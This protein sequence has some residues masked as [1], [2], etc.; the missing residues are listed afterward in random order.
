M[1]TIDVA[2]ARS[3]SREMLLG[4]QNRDLA[5]SANN[6]KTSFSSWDN[7]M[8]ATYCK[9]P[10]IAAII[11]GGLIVLSVVWCIVRCCCCDKKHK[12]LDEPYFPPAFAPHSGYKAPD[13]MMSGGGAPGTPFSPGP[14]DVRF[15]TGPNGMAIDPP[16]PVN[17]DALPPMPSWDSAAKRRI[18]IEDEPGAVEL[19]ELDP[20]L[21]AQAQSLE[22]TAQ[23]LALH[24]QERVP[25]ATRSCGAGGYMSPGPNGRPNDQ[26]SRNNS[27]NGY[28]GDQGLSPIGPPGQAY[29]GRGYSPQNQNQFI[30]QA[31]GGPDEQYGNHAIGNAYGDDRQSPYPGDNGGPQGGAF[32]VMPAPGFGQHQRNDSGQRPF[33]A[34]RA[35]VPAGPLGGGGYSGSDESYANAPR[36]GSPPILSNTSGYGP[37]GGSPPQGG[38]RGATPVDSS[39]GYRGGMGMPM[40]MPMPQRV[41]SPQGGYRGPPQRVDSPQGFR[42]PPQGFGG[43]PPQQRMGS[44]GPGRGGFGQGPERRGSPG[45]GPGGFG[46]GFPSPRTLEPRRLRD[47]DDD[48]DDDKRTTTMKKR[49]LESDV[50]A[51]AAGNAERQEAAALQNP[52][53]A[54]LSS[55]SDLEVTLSL[56]DAKQMPF[57]GTTIDN[58]TKLFASV[59]TTSEK[60]DRAA[61]LYIA[62]IELVDMNAPTEAPQHLL[63]NSADCIY[64]PMLATC[65][66]NTVLQY[67]RDNKAI[68]LELFL[69]NAKITPGHRYTFNL[70]YSEEPTAPLTDLASA[71]AQN[72]AGG[73]LILSA[74]GKPPTDPNA[75]SSTTSSSTSTS[76]R[77]SNGGIAKPTG[78]GTDSPDSSIA[79]STTVP[80]SAFPSGISSGLAPP[81]AP[82]NK[83][84]STG[85]KAGI[86]VGVAA[87][88]LIVIALLVA[89]WAR[90]TRRASTR[91]GRGAGEKESVLAAAA[92][93]GSGE[94]RDADEAGGA[95]VGGVVG[96]S[97]VTRKPV[98]VP[99]VANE[100][101]LADAVSPA[102]TTVG[103]V[104]AQHRGAGGEG[105]TQESMLNAEE[106]E[107]W[108]EEER[109]LDE[110]I[111]EAE[112]RR[113]GA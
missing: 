110:D 12:H 33:T 54:Q 41:D 69:T 9:W 60:I 34:D 81:S 17:D 25:T 87:A 50:R 52:T 105:A 67:S 113:L 107:R 100:A 86:G 112:R 48:D 83:G 51:M 53:N 56:N 4:L 7:C 40:P 84:L 28:G 102:S 45:P 6:V 16:K 98:G 97:P 72:G 37:R 31:Q 10:I 39:G 109:R 13:P 23:E 26:F 43:P 92:P 20:A 103:V 19:G 21:Q 79:T 22:P 46:Q 99:A 93:G 57:T 62:G 88:V 5:D 2:M 90:R 32:G 47:D 64:N 68:P 70:R 108:E 65:N 63:Q 104:G 55:G 29:G 74:D 73:D 85:A 94:Y 58:G 96:G 36:M 3:V 49:A 14:S 101:A 35:H 38:Y 15:E 1:P 18:S 77:L 42:G 111:A 89:W 82:S 78:T 11:V 66:I 30:G 71:T 76:S 59:T 95:V 106:R 80:S 8:K 91:N 24:P 75:A 27:N 61:T 44:P